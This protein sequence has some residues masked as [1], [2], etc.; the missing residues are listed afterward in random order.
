[1]RWPATSFPT[2]LFPQKKTTYLFS[3]IAPKEKENKRITTHSKKNQK[4]TSPARHDRVR[5]ERANG[6]PLFFF[7]FLARKLVASCI[8]FL[9]IPFFSCSFL[10]LRLPTPS[11]H[12]PIY[13]KKIFFLLLLPSNSLSWL[14]GYNKKITKRSRNTIHFWFFERTRQKKNETGKGMLAAASLFWMF[15]AFFPL[16]LG[17]QGK[18]KLWEHMEG[19]LPPQRKG[20]TPWNAVIHTE[21]RF[22]LGGCNRSRSIMQ[23][24]ANTHAHTPRSAAVVFFPSSLSVHWSANRCLS[25]ILLLTMYF[26]PLW[27]DCHRNDQH[28][29]QPALLSGH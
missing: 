10:I 1:M 18:K 26:N 9:K 7:L 19:P 28:A 4:K 14:G 29:T 23:S 22:T 11:L 27:Q 17:M 13:N 12:A 25:S 21:K 6:V 8:S 3:S 24:G 5:C 16:P 20:R 2:H 15:A